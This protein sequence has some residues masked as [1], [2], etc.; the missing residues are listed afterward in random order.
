M[1]HVNIRKRVRIAKPGHH[2]PRDPPS[3]KPERKVVVI[4]NYATPEIRKH[5]LALGANEVFDKSTEIDALV[6][7]CRALAAQ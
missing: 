2:R 6:D 7:Y 1:F 5:C 3:L 4:S